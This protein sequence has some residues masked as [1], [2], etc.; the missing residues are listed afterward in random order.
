LKDVVQIP[1]VID[2]ATSVW[3]QYTVRLPKDINR[4]KLM[5]GLK[6]AGIPTMV[7]YV[8][9]LHLQTAYNAYL[10][11][12]Y[13]SLPVCEALTNEVLSLPMSG[14][15]EGQD[16]IIRAFKNACINNR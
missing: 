4:A 12:G 5:A 7:Y 2:G 1:N 9:P 11:A 13:K 16:K 15:V 3:A 14:Y 6:E 10:T 8:K